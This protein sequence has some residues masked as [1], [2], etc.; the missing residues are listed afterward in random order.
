M[1]S[2]TA[3]PIIDA[4]PS[5][6]L[7]VCGRLLAAPPKR[8]PWSGWAQERQQ[9]MPVGEW[10]TLR[11]WFGGTVRLGD[12][13][14]AVIPRM[15]ATHDAAAFLDALA[16]LPIA[17]FLRV[18][19]TAGWVAPDMPLADADIL[20]LV[21]NRPAAERF[22]GEYA[23]LSGH[24]RRTMLTL[25]DNPQAARAELV[26][27]FQQIAERDFAP[28]APQ[29][30]AKRAEAAE[31]LAAR[32]AAGEQPEEWL[33]GS[34]SLTGF[35]PVVIAPSV[36]LTHHVSIYAHEITRSLLS[37]GQYEP[38]IILVNAQWTLT[39]SSARGRWAGGRMSPS[40]E[41]WASLHAALADPS[42]LRLLR[43]LAKRPWYGQ[44]L[45]AQLQMSAATISHHLNILTH[46][47]LISMERRAHRT[48]VVLHAERLRAR[49]HASASFILSE[50]EPS[51]PERA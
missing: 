46:A 10:Q 41:E 33:E 34:T 42:R 35:A 4:A 11:R 30:E 32:L 26:T 44:E 16:R 7:V 31:R 14:L 6:D 51:P 17:D 49:L 50:N 5:Y 1:G 18:A 2:E 3:K 36:L 43:L 40:A 23:R 13:Y 21:G 27:L 38:Y 48:Y 47:G 39:A 24:E 20:A 25:L 29:L 15:G 8:G 19:L 37:G 12:A 22:V 45:A 28:L 9:Q